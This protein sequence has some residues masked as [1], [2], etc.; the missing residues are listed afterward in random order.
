MRIDRQRGP[1]RPAVRAG[2]RHAAQPACQRPR[3]LAA[4]IRDID[5]RELGLRGRR[6]TDGHGWSAVLAVLSGRVQEG[7]VQK[8]NAAPSV[9]IERAAFELFRRLDDYHHQPLPHKPRAPNWSQPVHF[10]AKPSIAASQPASKSQLPAVMLNCIFV[11]RSV[12]LVAPGD[13]PPAA[14]HG[15]TTIL[16]V[17][18]IPLFPASRRRRSDA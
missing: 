7:L 14:Q 2:R 8:A 9:S 13:P 15:Y 5:G 18:Q 12:A 11:S 17:C 3:T 1:R 6:S 16:A 10:V 4:A